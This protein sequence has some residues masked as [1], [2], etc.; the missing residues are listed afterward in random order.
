MTIRDLFAHS[1]RM[2][3][4]RIIVGEVRRG[5]ALDMLQAM[6][7]G[8]AGALDDGSTPS[9]RRP[10][11]PGWRCSAMQSDVV[12]PASVARAL[13]AHAIDLVVQVARDAGG[14]RRVT[15]ITEVAGIDLDGQYQFRDILRHRATGQTPDGLP[16]GE[17]LAT[18]LAPS[19]AH[20]LHEEGLSSEARLS[21][22]LFAERD[23]VDNP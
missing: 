4:D 12:L 17:L 23:H 21:A 22:S 6:I 3:P 5:E 19:F 9:A 8:H 13:V 2:R 16:V 15:R 20:E 11:R 7:A 1:L 14:T 10:P 18:G